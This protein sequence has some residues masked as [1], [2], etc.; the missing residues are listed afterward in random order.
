ME[1]AIASAP[2]EAKGY[3]FLGDAYRAMNRLEL[4]R[5]AYTRA[6]QVDST[7][8]V[9]R[10]KVGHI[11]SFLGNYAEAREHYDAA[12]AGAREGLKVG[13]AN[14]RALTHVH[15][16][17]PRGALAELAE[18]E[19]S[20]TRLGIPEHQV[21]GARIGTLSLAAQ[22]ALHH[23]LTN[24]AAS[25]IDQLAAVTRADAARVGDTSYTRQQEATLLAWESQLAARK[26]DFAV[27]ASKAEEHKRLVEGDRNPRR[28][29]TYHALLGLIELR[30]GNHQAAAEHYRQ[31]DLTT[32]VYNK[33]HLA[34][35]LEGA[36]QASEARRL[37]QEVGAY[38][39]NSIG[40]AL[41]RADARKRAG[42]GET[43]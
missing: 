29:E 1:A 24:E 23:G 12:I 25:I 7:L 8:G 4:A 10:L 31:S 6:F 11:N 22:I 35:A 28:L 13:Y 9:A 43:G 40:F 2:G 37:F 38:N 5:S 20:A 42:T 32:D 17:D 19:R 27:A 3:E 16:G 18:V 36:G 14:F 39:F 15:G 34:L 21:G 30:K 41:A 33:Y 26:G